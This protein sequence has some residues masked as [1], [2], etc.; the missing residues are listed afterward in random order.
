[1]TLPL[2][3]GRVAAQES[4]AAA[5]ERFV[6]AVGRI[7][8]SAVEKRNEFILRAPANRVAEI[9]RRHRLTIIRPIDPHS[10]DVFLVEGPSTFGTRFDRIQDADLP[11]LE[12]LV[13]N[14]QGDREVQHFEANTAVVTPELASGINLNQTA[15]AIQA[16]LSD[17]TIVDYFGTPAWRGYV[18]QPAAGAINLSASQDAGATGA[19]IVAIIDTGVDP[20]HPLLQGS[21][22]PG[23]DFITDTP[24]VASEWSDV[25]GSLV[26]ILDG[27]LV[28]ILD[29]SLV[30][31]LD[32]TSVVVLNGS[33]VGI[34]DQD[35]A[36]TLDPSQLPAAFGHGTMVAGLVHLVAPTAK[37]MPLK[38]FR[39]DGTSTV[40]DVVRAIQYA[41]EHGARV[42]NMSFSATAISPE[43]A[44]AINVATSMGVIC[45]AS[46]GNLG[47]E[48]LVY[49]AALRNVLSVA[50]T[51][52][53]TPAARSSF[54]NYGAALVSL[55]APG[56]GVITS[57]P[58]GNYAGAW[59]TS[60]SAPLAAGAA[61]LLLQA[62]PTLDQAKADAVLGNAD[63][64]DPGTGKGRLNL[65]QTARGMGDATPP[66]VMVTAPTDG[67]VVFSTVNI[68]ASAS[69]NIRVAGVTFFL[70]DKA[71]G[72]ED[73][74]APY[75]ATW[76][77]TDTTNGS[78]VVKALA[79]DGAG[80]ESS[81]SITVTVSNDQA[82]PTVVL[83]NPAADTTVSGTV[84]L[85]ATATDDHH[86]FGVQFKV[87]GALLGSEDGA[88]PFAVAWDTRTA[89]NGIHML[90]AI[91]RDA[92][93]K[94][95]TTSVVVTVLNPTGPTVANDTTAPTVVFTPP[96]GD[97]LGRIVSI[98]ATATDDIGVVGVQF[99]M[100]GVNLGVED[101]LAP[102]EVLWPALSDGQHTL[103]AVARD[104]AGNQASTSIPVMVANE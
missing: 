64:L 26:S 12:Q 24:G 50:S 97:G 88:E 73:A 91:A 92:S 60:F 51:T 68:A 32:Q 70:D 45:V 1:M 33:T 37:I 80:N 59:G 14:V 95:A 43:I 23:Y 62:D 72:P 57:Y 78:H 13:G 94:E 29:G 22:V 21:L 75:E 10:H 7:R 17:R 25:D 34:L 47:Q 6:E 77:T 18:A 96:V 30:S 49:P 36:E 41:V 66:A 27:S 54:S 52:S 104:A 28:S 71:L 53:T 44:H 84:T 35:T 82:A 83:T 38:A 40:F 67:S 98:G 63:R 58:G 8:Q 4:N 5:Q 31:I 55:G 76:W 69:D 86:V 16:S 79:R 46:A 100:D 2:T 61:A 3:R 56:E 81:S 19:G 93:G 102:Y 65:D 15:A 20:N 85:N 89:S 90:T 11:A 103:T 74:A 42:I 48:L 87:D 101:T 39:S 9:A 99:L